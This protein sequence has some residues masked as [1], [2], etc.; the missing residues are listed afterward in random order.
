MRGKNLLIIGW[1]SVLSSLF[2]LACAENQPGTVSLGEP[3]TLLD[4]FTLA[5]ER[6][7][8]SDYAPT[9][10]NGTINVVIEIPA[11]TNEKWEVD[12]SSGALKWEFRD[13]APRRVQYMGYPGNYGMIPRTV[14]PTEDG[15]DGDPLDVIVLGSAVPRG[16]VVEARSIGVLKLLDNDEVDDKIIAVLIGSPF[17]EI[18]K[19]KDLNL[20]FQGVTQML[21]I[22]F[23]NYKGP[24]KLES[25]GFGD[26]IEA[27]KVIR[28]AIQAFQKHR[29]SSGG[30]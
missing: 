4:P 30:Q 3:L 6:N 25:T 24:G 5:G 22:W 9:N 8:L 17:E 27:R 11:G 18:T 16:S 13:G 26:E 14:L 10:S 7:L 12:K 15:G 19:L 20:R 29:S 28:S 21:E 2:S 23:E 1:V